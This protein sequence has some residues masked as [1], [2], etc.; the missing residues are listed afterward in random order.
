MIH[1]KQYCRV[2]KVENIKPTSIIKKT[3]PCKFV[4]VMTT[5]FNKKKFS[6]VNFKLV[7]FSIKVS[8]V[9]QAIWLSFSCVILKMG[10]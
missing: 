3:I 7:S 8:L 4:K 5:F 2:H 6:F 10:F 9:F 1:Q